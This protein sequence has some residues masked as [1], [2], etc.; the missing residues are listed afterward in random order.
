MSDSYKDKLAA[1]AGKPVNLPSKPLLPGFDTGRFEQQPAYDRAELRS[2]VV[3]DASRRD[4]RISIRIS[5]K[6]LAELHKQALVEGIPTQSLIAKVVHQYVQSLLRGAGRAGNNKMDGAAAG[7]DVTGNDSRISD[8]LA[9][10]AG[11]AGSFN[12]PAAPR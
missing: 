3:D 1:L 8:G 9:D 11:G 4:N 10:S 7:V 2:H 12:K 5:G 6:D